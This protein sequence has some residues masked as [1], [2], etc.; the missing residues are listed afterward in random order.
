MKPSVYIETTVISYLTAQIPNIIDKTC[1]SAG[2]A[3]PVICTP[4]ELTGV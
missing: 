2:Y 3:P 4:Y 1:R